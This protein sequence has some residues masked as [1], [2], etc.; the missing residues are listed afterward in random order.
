MKWLIS[1]FAALSLAFNIACLHGSNDNK[2]MSGT[3]DTVEYA[4]CYGTTPCKACT[5]CAYCQ[6]CKDGGTCG[7][8]A[9]QKKSKSTTYKSPVKTSG[10]CQAIT[11]KGTRCSRS[12]R[13][14]G[15]CWQH[16]G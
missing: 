13:S 9:Q 11:K 1:S 10:R 3:L 15:Y 7:M 14:N 2:P 5:S 12:A 8:C 6:W 4:R 16:G